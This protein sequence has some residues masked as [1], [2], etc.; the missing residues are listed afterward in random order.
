VIRVFLKV[1]CGDC[2]GVISY[3]G[4]NADRKCCCHLANQPEKKNSMNP[5]LMTTSI[6]VKGNV[7]LL[8]SI[9]TEAII[10]HLNICNIQKNSNYI[11][12]YQS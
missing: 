12:N 6:L 4:Y 1:P 9:F 8:P 10:I 7:G 5:K 3:C 11:F 2:R